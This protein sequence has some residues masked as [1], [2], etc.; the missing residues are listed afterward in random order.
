MYLVNNCMVPL[1][2][3]KQSTSYAE[4][5]RKNSSFEA[6]RQ[7]RNAS[8]HISFLGSGIIGNSVIVRRAPSLE[9][10]KKVII[11]KENTAAT[12]ARL[13]S[14]FDIREESQK[15]VM[16]GLPPHSD[17]LFWFLNCQ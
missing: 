10:H 6:R 11:D 5:L 4:Q 13:S 8:L 12:K 17:K 7:N 14:V 2:I 16:D 1:T 3:Y 15:V 9:N